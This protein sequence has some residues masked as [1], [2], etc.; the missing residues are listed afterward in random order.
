MSSG[1]GEES[2]EERREGDAV[3]LQTPCFFVPVSRSQELQK[4]ITT[5]LGILISP[6]FQ[7][8]VV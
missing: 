8:R 3:E 4:F 7:L 5:N 1:R 2:E 6:Q